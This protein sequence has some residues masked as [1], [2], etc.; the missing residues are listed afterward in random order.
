MQS[1]CGTRSRIQTAT[2]DR[3]E[4]VRLSTYRVAL[5]PIGP[6]RDDAVTGNTEERALHLR[7]KS[8]TE[9]LAALTDEAGNLSLAQP[10]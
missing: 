8:E 5:S 6:I 9:V 7:A 1:I 10:Q 4:I 2:A 3:I